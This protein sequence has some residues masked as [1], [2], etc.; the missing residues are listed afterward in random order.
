[1]EDEESFPHENEDSDT[2]VRQHTKNANA[3]KQLFLAYFAS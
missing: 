1:V 3:Q 2:Y